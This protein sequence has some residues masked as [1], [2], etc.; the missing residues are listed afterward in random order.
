MRIWCIKIGNVLVLHE[1]HQT[2]FGHKE[3]YV[4]ANYIVD[5]DRK[6]CINLPVIEAKETSFTSTCLSISRTLC[7]VSLISSSLGYTLYQV[8][9]H[10]HY[11]H[12]R[13]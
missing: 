4:M 9:T 6:I 10:H 3:C 8:G 7:M 13:Y 5:N 11:H 2:I 1:T 12:Y